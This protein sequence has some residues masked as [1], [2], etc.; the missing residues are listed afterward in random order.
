M[1]RASQKSILDSIV[2]TDSVLDPTMLFAALYTDGPL[3]TPPTTLEDFDM[4]VVADLPRIA[5]A[6]WSLS[7][8]QIGEGY[9]KTSPLLTFHGT[10][11]AIDTTYKGVL[12]ADSLTSGALIGYHDF[13]QPLALV[14]TDSFIKLVLTILLGDDVLKLG[15]I[16]VA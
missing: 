13:P 5:V 16:V 4:P 8:Y 6:S 11:S 14:D 12:L 15:A 2:A 1:I 7:D 9:E 10:G 3:T